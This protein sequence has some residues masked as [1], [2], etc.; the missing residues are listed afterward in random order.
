MA[1]QKLT[2][3]IQQQIRAGYDVNKIRAY[4]LK[5][6]YSPQDVNSAVNAIYHP[7]VKHVV[8]HLS[9]NTIITI[10]IIAVI[11]V[12]IPAAYFFFSGPSQ[13][14]QLL[15]LRTSAVTSSVREGGKVEFNIE[16]SNLGKSK[17]YDVFLKHEIIGTDIY[18]DET[19]AVETTTSKTSY[20]QLTQDIIPRRYTVKT[21]ASYNDKRAF[22]TFGFDVVSREGAPEKTC[23]ESWKCDS[24]Q[25][26]ECPASGEQ[27]RTCTDSNSCGTTKTMPETITSCTYVSGE[28][29]PEEAPTQ[30][31]EGE[32]ADMNIW[33]QLDFIKQTAKTDPAK[34]AGYCT[35]LEIESHRDECYYNIAESALSVAGCDKIVSERTKDK[36]VNN[37]AKISQS[38]ILCEDIV[39]QSRK[40]S[41]YMNFVNNGDYT[42]CDKIDNSYLKDACEALRDMPDI[43]VQ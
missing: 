10:A 8:H 7:D 4:L 19:I 40:D 29:P 21:T 38:S 28:K 43:V 22:S 2:T 33:E 42:V 31:V 39:K 18:K 14:A 17:R 23:T 16:L 32:F 35:S 41:C 26:V 27:T 9:K 3:Y 6:G 5:Y 13:S 11:I 25:P 24:W 1:D 34:A 12:L 15:D 20:I 37:I 30:P 36:C